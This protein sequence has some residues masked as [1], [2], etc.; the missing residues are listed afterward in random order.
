MWILNP[1]PSTRQPSRQ[2]LAGG[3]LLA[4]NGRR[5]ARERAAALQLRQRAVSHRSQPLSQ[6]LVLAP[7]VRQLALHVHEVLE[8]V[9]VD[10]DA[11][12]VAHQRRHFLH[13]RLHLRPQLAP[14]A[15]AVGQRAP[16]TAILG[17]QV[18]VRRLAFRHLLERFRSLAVNL[19]QLRPQHGEKLL[20]LVDAAVAQGVLELADLE[21]QLLVGLFRV[22]QFLRQCFVVVL[23]R[24]EAL[25]LLQLVLGRLRQLLL[26]GQQ[27][28]DLQPLVFA[29]LLKELQTRT[30][31]K[32]KHRLSSNTDYNE[33][34][35][36]HMCMHL[37]K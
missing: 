13:E 17:V 3:L 28:L 9:A 25:D 7:H 4:S 21:A 37:K 16:Q 23:D 14:H 30:T 11:R 6:R 18:F 20:L 27:A 19:L 26:P 33:G 31:A 29:L 34:S 8:V 2:V 1:S 22:C 15:L 10:L 36:T 12:L 35:K 32:Q 5:R 24:P